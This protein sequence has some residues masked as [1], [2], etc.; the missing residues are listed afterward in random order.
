MESTGTNQ[1]NAVRST[2]REIHC[3]ICGRVIGK[4]S[5]GGAAFRCPRCKVNVDVDHD[6]GILITR[7]TLK[8]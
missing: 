3:N 8:G 5:L 2:K 7:T 4:I 6:Q 1:N